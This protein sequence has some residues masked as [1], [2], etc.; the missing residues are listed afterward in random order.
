MEYV[1]TNMIEFCRTKQNTFLLIRDGLEE[2]MEVLCKQRDKR[3]SRML[4]GLP[5][6]WFTVDTIARRMREIKRPT[7]PMEMVSAVDKG[8]QVTPR[9]LPHRSSGREGESLP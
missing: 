4:F 2:A 5:Y 8:T 7:G 6:D 9:K 3:R 1:L